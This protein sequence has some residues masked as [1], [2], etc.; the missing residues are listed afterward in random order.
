MKTHE[1]KIA[2]H[3]QRLDIQAAAI[4]R[5]DSCV[6]DLS[7]RLARLE[8]SPNRHRSASAPPPADPNI[9]REAFLGGFPSLSRAALLAKAQ[10]IVGQPAGLE[11]VI[12]PLSVT[13]GSFAYVRF[14]SVEAMKA[15]VEVR[16]NEG[17]P[18]G[19]RLKPNR[20]KEQ[21]HRGGVIFRGKQ[22]L[23]G[24]GVDDG[25]IAFSS[26]RFWQI[27]P[28]GTALELGKLEGDQIV[29]GSSAPPQLRS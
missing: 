11:E 6:T 23:I 17:L 12:V 24:A 1:T 16:N 20:T 3:A 7:D 9:Q 4:E 19:L 29:W 5:H 8:S 25:S 21:R 10:H 26:S 28:D 18:G 27:A 13:V 22:Q 15:F 2:D 14:V